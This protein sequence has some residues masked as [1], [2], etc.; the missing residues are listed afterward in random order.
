MM[1]R[2]F[3]RQCIDAEVDHWAGIKH[4]S[5]LRKIWFRYFQSESNAV[6]LVRTFQF[7][8]AQSGLL[9]KVQAR[10]LE[11]V[12]MRR[13]GIFIGRRC[14]IGIGF[15]IWHPHGIIINNV[16]IG[17]NFNVNQNCTIGDKEHGFNKCPVIGN[18]VTMYA[19][20]MIIGSVR[21]DD[22]VVLGANACLLQDTTG[23]GVYVGTPAKLKSSKR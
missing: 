20:S 22:N 4:N 17:E 6:Y 15:R 7:H 5:W 13:Y 2:K 8:S 9:H 21:V 14:T 1:D 3:Y 12:L 11:I 10:F 19:N 18:N 16:D 23:S